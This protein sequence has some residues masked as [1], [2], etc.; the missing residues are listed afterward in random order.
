VL[1]KKFSRT[2][3][4]IPADMIH[5]SG[6]LKYDPANNTR[7]VCWYPVVGWLSI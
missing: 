3:V 2:L 4:N 5:I 7:I 6:E 1:K